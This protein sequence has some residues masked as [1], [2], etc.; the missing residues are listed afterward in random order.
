MSQSPDKKQIDK[1]K[2]AAR[3]LETNND[4]AEFD[5]KVKGMK[6]QTKKPPKARKKPPA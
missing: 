4:P 6:L 2:E 1:F 3:E 5:R